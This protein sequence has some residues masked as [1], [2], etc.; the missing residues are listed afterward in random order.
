[1]TGDKNTGLR[2]LTGD[3]VLELHGKAVD[4][5]WDAPLAESLRVRIRT[6]IPHLADVLDRPDTGTV[7]VKVLLRLTAKQD[8]TPAR[9]T[10]AEEDWQALPLRDSL[11]DA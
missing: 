3:Q 5:G 4:K 9:M 8:A 10:I 1:M 7:R 11:L 6:D 2:V